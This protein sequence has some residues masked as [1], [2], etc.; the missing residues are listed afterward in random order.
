MYGL[1]FPELRILRAGYM[2]E[3]QLQEDA[4]KGFDQSDRA[5]LRRFSQELD[6]GEW[7]AKH[8]DT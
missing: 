7:H 6:S 2:V 8:S 4:E 3:R 5:D 1:L